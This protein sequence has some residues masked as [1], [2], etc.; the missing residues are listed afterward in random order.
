MKSYA[1]QL[2]AERQPGVS[3]SVEQRRARKRSRLSKV[4][5]ILRRSHMYLAL[6]LTPWMTMYALSTVVFNHCERISGLYGGKMD[7][8]DK[9]KELAYSKA[10]P[11][12]A[13]PG[14]IAGEILKDLD[15]GGDANVETGDE[16][17]IVITRLDPLRPTRI[18]Y[19][20]SQKKLVVE[21]QVFRIPGFLTRMHARL[22]YC[23]RYRMANVWA[24]CVDLSIFATLLWILS[25]FWLWWELKVTRRWG[26]LSALAGLAL[27]AMFLAMA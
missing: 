18:T 16:G 2:Q 13:K 8:F 23:S 4:S 7:R 27:F 10:F 21:K 9:A 12:G 26:W 15:L 14:L 3:S 6:F 22:G 17:R 11:P 20:P 5:L 24:F 19:F 1:M 25:G